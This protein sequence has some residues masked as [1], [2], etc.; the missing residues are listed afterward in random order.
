MKN[1]YFLFLY[2]IISTFSFGQASELY[3][4]MYGEG[5]SNNKFLEIY[6]GTGSSVDLSNYAIDIYFNGSNSVSNTLILSG[7]LS[8]NDVY[9]IYNSSADVVI[10]NNGDIAGGSITNFN[11]DDAIALTKSNTIIDLIGEIGI[12]PGSGWS[13]GLSGNTANHTLI[14]K[15]SICDPNPNP[16]GSFTSEWYTFPTD[17]QWDKIGSHA[18]CIA[19]NTPTIDATSSVTGFFYYQN[20]GPSGEDTFSVSASNLTTDVVITAP[21]NF[22]ISLNSGTNY[23]NSL[24]L[25]PSNGTVSLTTI[26]VRMVSGLTTNNYSGN[27]TL[28]S[29]GAT[30]VTVSLSGNVAPDDPIIFI[31]G[32]ISNLEYSLGN[33]PSAED[34]FTVEGLFLT[35]NITVTAPSDF[36][37]SLTNGSNFASSVTVN[38]TG[39]T[40]AET[41]IYI[42]MIAGLSENTYS[43]NVT[44]S[45]TNAA[46]KTISVSG[47]VNPAAI[48]SSVGDIIITEIMKNPDI[49]TDANGEY[50]EIYNKTESAI[51]LKGWTISDADGE[52]YTIPAD[53]IINSTSYAI[54]G[55]NSDYGTN[56]GVTVDH[57]YTGLNLA[58]SADE[59]IIS[60]SSTIIDE[61]YYNDSDFPD[62][63]G[64]SM[65]LSTTTLNHTDNDTGINWGEGTST[66]G[67][68]D[69]GT[70]GTANDF[71]LSNQK[72]A[73]EGFKLFPNPTSLGYV[74]ITAKSTATMNVSIYNLLG[75]QIM[76]QT[77]ANNTLDISKLNTGIYILKVSQDKAI[78]TQ[79]LIIK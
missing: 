36:E 1:L 79:K 33:G 8:N 55:I 67:A 61:V 12:D 28:T 60:C 18:G 49:V 32:S 78:A 53:L 22:E 65:Q 73:I 4:S 50:F 24:N 39:G 66:F 5:S 3:F 6:N 27:I 76:K 51:N 47:T 52:S 69:L 20:N 57:E 11:G 44:A 26:Y 13:V 43:G 68:G 31:N 30:D 62:T 25:T 19:S 34:S 77:V 10:V 16:T 74:N 9:V 7:I 41:T 38:Q 2:F 72:I 45:S 56:G 54:L 37:V 75:K 40:A 59:V 71:T 17:D 63:P 46:N 35:D 64:V 23:T 70:P 48:C 21:T 14:R 42:R 58:N 15:E 29:T